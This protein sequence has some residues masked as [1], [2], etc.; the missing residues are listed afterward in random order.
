[1]KNIIKN[2]LMQM[3]ILGFESL[4]HE[5]DKNFC[6]AL[7]NNLGGVIFFSRNFSTV[8]NLKNDIKIMKEQSQTPLFISID[9]EGGLVERT[10]TLDKKN[11]YLSPKAVSRLSEQDIE[12]HYTILCQELNYLGFNMNFAPCVDTDTN[13]QNPIISLRAFSKDTNIVCKNSKIVIDVMKNNNI[14]SVAKHFPGH[15]DCNVDSHKSMP[16]VSGDFNKF[17]ETH[18]KPFKTSVENDI[19]AIMVGHI[20]CKFNDKFANDDLPATLSKDI[21]NYL[22]NDLI[23]NG[24]II[25]D[26]MV[27]GGISKYFT[28]EDSIIKG[29]FAGIE[30]FIFK[31]TTPELLSVIDN[32]AK[33]ANR[34]KSLKNIIEK[35]YNKIIEFKKKNIKNFNNNRF[36]YKSSQKIIDNL[37]KKSIV[38][39]NKSKLIEFKN[40]D[41]FYILRFNPSEIYN[42]SFDNFSFKN[43]LKNLVHEEIFYSKNP[44]DSEILNIINKLNPAIPVIFISYNMHQNANQKKLLKKILNKKIIISTG[45]EYEL[46]CFDKK[47]IIFSTLSPKP[48]SLLASVE[49]LIENIAT[50]SD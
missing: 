11:N 28:L 37:A 36:D 48:C 49:L 41:K 5:N 20:N 8:K 9:Q 45:N 50:N 34:N 24:L 25:S 12:K 42:L 39:M 1:M 30:I 7:K 21:I 22:K 29:I 33:F 14:I 3:F 19:N 40:T 31:D 43:C 18:V 13:P 10:S 47:D 15:G 44:S 16:V 35:N 4:N 32:I 26:D 23:F 17:Y 38:V 6:S 27:M 2:K 46:N